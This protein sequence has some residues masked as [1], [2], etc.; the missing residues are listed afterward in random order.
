MS[1]NHHDVRTA[2]KML[3]HGRKH[4]IGPFQRPKNRN[5]LLLKSTKPIPP[6]R[7]DAQSD[8]QDGR[9]PTNEQ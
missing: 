1:K 3:E 4:G 9:E 5:M 8:I 6:T 7:D 2:R